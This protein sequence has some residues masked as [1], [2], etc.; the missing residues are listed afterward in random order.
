M[1]YEMQRK[2]MVETQLIPRGIHDPL[3]LKAM[4]KVPREAFVPADL[5]ESAC[6]D[7]PLPIGE[8]QTIS[9]PYIVALMTEALELKGPEK[10]LEIGT[11]SGYQAA[12]LQPR[13]RSGDELG[14]ITRLPAGDK[15]SVFNDFFVHEPGPR[16]FD[17][18]HDGLPPGYF[19]ALQDIRG[20]KNLRGMAN[21]KNRLSTVDKVPYKLNRFLMGSQLIRRVT[22]GD[23]Q[24]IKIID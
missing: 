5:R 13:K 22:S 14:K 20:N 9:Q 19:A 10:V 11:G 15:V 8:G 16:I 6:D 12:L 7:N 2:R 18:L 24:G 4:E 17:V 1:T 21:G 23:Q 3:V